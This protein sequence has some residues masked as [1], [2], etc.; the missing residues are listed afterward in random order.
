MTHAQNQS[1]P[2]PEFGKV[3]EAF[4]EIS[5]P[6]DLITIVEASERRKTHLILVVRR[7]A[8]RTGADVGDLIQL[9]E[10]E[11]DA[12]RIRLSQQLTGAQVAA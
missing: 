12:I 10:G 1:S 8:A 5:Q 7:L 2:L 6:K 4:R 11:L 9:G 3:L